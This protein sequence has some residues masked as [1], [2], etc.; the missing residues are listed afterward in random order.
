MAHTTKVTLL[1]PAFVSIKSYINPI[2]PNV[3]YAIAASQRFVSR[4]EAVVA[5]FDMSSNL[6]RFEGQ[7]AKGLRPPC[8]KQS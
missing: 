2:H 5:S 1:T 6:L 8:V 3:A 7:P 4:H